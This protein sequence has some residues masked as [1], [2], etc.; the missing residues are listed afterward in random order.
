MVTW[1]LSGKGEDLKTDEASHE[2]SELTTSVVATSGDG[3]QDV[4]VLTGG[5]DSK[6]LIWSFRDRCPINCFTFGH[7][8]GGIT[9]L[10]LYDSSKYN[11]RDTRLLSVGTDG[12]LLVWDYFRSLGK[13]V[14]DCFRFPTA[15]TGERHF[16]LTDPCVC[17]SPNNR[18]EVY[19]TTA[20]DCGKVVIWEVTKEEVGSRQQDSEAE[21]SAENLDFDVQSTASGHEKY[22]RHTVHSSTSS[23]VVTEE[24]AEYL[25]LGVRSTA[26]GRKKCTRHVVHSSISSTVVTSGFDKSATE[27]GLTSG[28]AK[29]RLAGGRQ[30]DVAHSDFTTGTA[31]IPL[32][33]DRYEVLTVDV[34]GLSTVWTGGS[35]VKEHPETCSGTSLTHEKSRKV[36]GPTSYRPH[37]AHATKQDYTL[38]VSE[39]STC[40]TWDC[41]SRNV[42][43]CPKDGH[44]AALLDVCIH[45]PKKVDYVFTC[46]KDSRT[47]VWS[48]DFEKKESKKYVSFWVTKTRSVRL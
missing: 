31:V 47:V 35:E 29:Y 22:T 13:V 26:S 30:A 36:Y 23:T 39:D 2:W 25:D 7:K 14:D 27:W 28:R 18:D 15:S 48:V 3:T 46:S 17:A 5:Q 34:K 4:K 12:A 45:R 37:T 1:D 43:G 33:E 6:V 19:T 32:G 42:V 9:G 41:K 20:T 11:K 44:S 8:Q 16:D 38:T 24:S 10:A 21:E 40:R